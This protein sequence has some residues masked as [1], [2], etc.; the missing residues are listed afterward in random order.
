M[1]RD[2]VKPDKPDPATPTS[3]SPFTLADALVE[4][5][6]R[7]LRQLRG[8]LL[9]ASE[10][11]CPVAI[12]DL[13]RDLEALLET[14][15]REDR[16]SQCRVF[17]QK[18]RDLG[19]FDSI[20]FPEG[21]P[22]LGVNAERVFGLADQLAA[23][24][25]E[26]QVNSG[27]QKIQKTLDPSPIVSSWRWTREEGFFTT[28]P[29]ATH[30]DSGISALVIFETE[31]QGK[32]HLKHLE[33]GIDSCW[34]GIRRPLTGPK[35]PGQQQADEALQSA[36]ALAGAETDP[37]KPG[38][39]TRIE[40]IGR[41]AKALRLR[42]ESGKVF[43]ESTLEERTKSGK[44][45][46]SRF[47][48]RTIDGGNIVKLIDREGLPTET[49]TLGAFVRNREKRRQEA[50]ARIIPN[51]S[52][53]LLRSTV[54]GNPSDEHRAAIERNCEVFP[55]SNP[56]EGLAS[57]KAQDLTR[58]G[59]RVDLAAAYDETLATIGFTDA[60]RAKIAAYE[61]WER[62]KDK[63]KT[64]V[65][66]IRPTPLAFERTV[67]RQ[68]SPEGT[69]TSVSKE[70]AA[71]QMQAAFL[72]T[73]NKGFPASLMQTTLVLFSEAFENGGTIAQSMPWLLRMHGMQ[74]GSNQ[75][76]LMNARLAILGTHEF[77]F[78][79]RPRKSR[80]TDT[81]IERGW[82][83][84]PFM[85]KLATRGRTM[86]GGEETIDE[87]EWAI[88][89]RFMQLMHAT[90]ALA[91]IDRS[92]FMLDATRQQRWEFNIG[93]WMATRWSKGWLGDEHLHEVEGRF[94]CSVGTLLERSGLGLV[95]REWIE[96]RG[97]DWKGSKR[98][99]NTPFRPRLRLA[100][101][102]LRRCGPD[103]AEAIGPFE[104]KE[105]PTD[106]LLDR[107]IVEP[108]DAQVAVFRERVLGKAETR[109]IAAQAKA[110]PERPK[111]EKSK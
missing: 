20:G 87:F 99:S 11:G 86:P 90:R 46:P 49:T 15:A 75:R 39:G 70:D 83:R 41:S 89:Q 80:R 71:K 31:A 30:R 5:Q 78:L 91:V 17:L 73:I 13:L 60:S 58:W 103:R 33:P 4:S 95:G 10:E 18:M 79:Q 38:G 25:T 56:D 50:D 53:Q 88:D 36:S 100:L 48:A 61:A 12:R 59:G 81:A 1:K 51:R 21:A 40:I 35:I 108:T 19:L 96:K 57:Q 69:N 42:S 84:Y 106:P 37:A 47:E 34:I 110:L 94:E 82:I 64:G 102:T 111:R 45:K 63:R 7:L 54:S 97:V 101:E 27:L 24:V 8:I 77:E 26:A 23:S 29:V 3:E 104:I 66:I 105:H 109:A 22:G 93:V 72:E 16:S 92:L 68:V 32:K 107:V 85:H 28:A 2:S 14:D 76:R 98:S 62:R 65:Q 6:D 43:V 44:T 55:H 67:I 74:D 52:D 9:A